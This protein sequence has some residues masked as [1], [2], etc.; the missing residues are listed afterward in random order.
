MSD[1][2]SGFVTGGMKATGAVITLR[3][4]NFKPRRVVVYNQDNLFRCEWI[5]RLADLAA[6]VTTAAG[7]TTLVAAAGITPLDPNTAG[8][9]GFSLGALANIN[10]TTTEDLIWEAHE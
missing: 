7:V 9:P 2:G 4:M 6:L 8:N 5:D 10:D 1:V 3:K